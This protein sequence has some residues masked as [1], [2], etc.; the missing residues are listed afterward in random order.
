MR[1]IAEEELSKLERRMEQLKIAARE[2]GVTV[3]EGEDDEVV[4]FRRRA[5]GRRRATRSR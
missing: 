3:D 5:A 4:L 2:A 1:E